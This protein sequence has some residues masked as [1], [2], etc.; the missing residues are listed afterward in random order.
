MRIFLAVEL[1]E[2]IRSGIAAVQDSLARSGIRNIRWVNPAGI[3]LTLRFIGEVAPEA[4]DRIARALAPGVPSAPFSVGIGGLGTFPPKGAPRVLF[5]VV[6]DAA[7][8]PEIA[9]WVEERVVSAGLPPDRRPFHPHLTLG[10]FRTGGRPLSRDLLEVPAAR[11]LG[12]LPVE[13]IV[14]FRSHLEPRGAR[15][16]ALESFPLIGGER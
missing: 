12:V 1:N 6:K 4:A 7:P 16:E 10:R 15:Y 14:M 9:A 13:R 11:D 2:S 3:H 8:L 5:A